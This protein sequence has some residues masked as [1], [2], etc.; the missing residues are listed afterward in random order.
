VGSAAV[1]AAALLAA[2]GGGSSNDSNQPSGTYPVKVVSASFPSK[3][4]VG[5]TALMKIAVKNTGEK[6]VPDLTVNVGIEG[7]EGEGA[8]IPFAVHDPQ[9]GLANADRPV[10]VLAARYPRLEGE[11]TPAGAETSSPQTYAFGEVKPGKTVETVFKL[12]AV[13]PGK[14]TVAYEVGAGLGA[15]VKA[16]T[17]GGTAPGGS[18]VATITTELAETEVNGA[19]EI[20]NVG[21]PVK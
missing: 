6:T 20:V 9:V 4:F 2:C 12:S 7:K 19:G 5:Q 18:F 10:W 3:Q 16:K 1:A 8:Q 21:P 13:R 11:S 17:A 15:E 14:Y